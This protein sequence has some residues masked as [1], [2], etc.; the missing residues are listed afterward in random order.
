MKATK[1]LRSKIDGLAKGYVFTCSNFDT[2]VYGKEAIIKAL[3]RMVQSGEINKLAKGKFYKPKHSK[4]GLLEPPSQQ[5][6]KDL[7]SK[8][9]KI[10]GYLTGLSI[11]NQ[12]GLSSQNSHVIEIG[13]N[14]SKAPLTRGIFKVKFL[15]QKNKITKSHIYYLQLLDSL[16]NLKSIPDTTNQDAI[17]RLRSLV[18]DLD[19]VAKQV[20]LIL[21]LQYSPVTRALLGSILEDIGFDT[22]LSDLKDSLNPV[23]IYKNYNIETVIRSASKWGIL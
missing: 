15:L 4:F 22:G 11:Y 8:K 9:S 13:R 6:V 18:K 16:K 3:N 17:K 19:D 1:Y 21:S 12:L 20:L 23:T 7:L 2:E 14:T 10:I 5:I